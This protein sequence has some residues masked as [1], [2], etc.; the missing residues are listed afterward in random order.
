MPDLIYVHGN[1][2][3]DHFADE[4]DP[5]VVPGNREETRR[6]LAHWLSR[7]CEL[8]EAEGVIVFGGHGPN[9][10]L[11]PTETYG[12]AKVVNLPYGAEVR[13]EVA[14]PANREANDRRV[15]VVTEDHRLIEAL[16]HGKARVQT[17]AQFVRKARRSMGSEQEAVPGEPEQKFTGP[18]DGEVDFWMQYF[19]D[20]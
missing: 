6:N 15:F 16:R 9:E 17:P 7:Y 12:A 14:G 20:E 18:S 5:L 19:E 2:L 1:D 10:V 3:L 11:P 13:T 8:R 4:D